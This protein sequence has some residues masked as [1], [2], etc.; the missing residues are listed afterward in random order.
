M[1]KGRK[2]MGKGEDRRLKNE[3]EKT[4]QANKT[5]KKKQKAGK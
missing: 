1:A 5:A 2:K 3:A 4:N